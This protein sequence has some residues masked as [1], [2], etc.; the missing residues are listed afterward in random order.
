M[1][2]PKKKVNLIVKF[3]QIYRVAFY[4]NN[5]RIREDPKPCR[6]CGDPIGDFIEE[7]PWGQ[8]HLKRKHRCILCPVLMEPR[9]RIF[10]KLSSLLME[11]NKKPLPH[12]SIWDKRWTDRGYRQVYPGAGRTFAG[13]RASTITK[14]LDSTTIDALFSDKDALTHLFNDPTFWGLPDAYRFEEFD[15][16]FDRIKALGKELFLSG[17]ES[18]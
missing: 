4:N 9:Q 8:E 15:P 5:I 18:L 1:V 14:S 16:K 10:G 13:T 3:V 12:P 11:K 2:T 17:R 7:I 6:I